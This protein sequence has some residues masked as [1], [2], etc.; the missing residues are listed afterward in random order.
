MFGVTNLMVH[1]S[2]A[3]GNGSSLGMRDRLAVHELMTRMEFLQRS[4]DSRRDIDNECGYPA[5]VSAE[6]Y[7]KLWKRSGIARRVVNIFPKESWKKWPSIIED[8]DPTT[9]TTFEQ[10]ILDLVKEKML[11][12]YLKRADIMSGIG[13]YGVLLL[14]VDD[15]AAAQ[16]DLS[17]PIEGVTEDEQPAGVVSR[18]LLWMRVFAENKATIAKYNTNK[19]SPRFMHPEQYSLQ[20]TDG[21]QTQSMTV[22]WTRCLHFADNRGES[23]IAGSPRMESEYNRLYDLNKILGAS[24]EGYWKGAF[25]GIASELMAGFEDAEVDTDAIRQAIWNYQNTLQRHLITPGMTNKTLDP[26]ILGPYEFFETEIK[27]ICVGIDVPLRVFLGT[28]EGKLAGE[29]DDSRWDDRVEGR[30]V[31]YLNPCVVEP[32]I[33]RLQAIGVCSAPEDWRADWPDLKD[34][35]DREESEV[36]LIKTQAISEY[37]RG[38]CNEF[39]PEEEYL[40]MFLNMDQEEVE[41]IIEA[42]E[43]RVE[44]LRKEEE[45]Q[46]RK[47][48]DAGLLDEEDDDDNDQVPPPNQG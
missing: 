34:T 11:W 48:I 10:E 35:S 8:D 40:S 6:Q 3:S 32:T 2:I 9:T 37:V 23:D 39:I 21:V 38:G 12:H 1:N 17:Q 4:L 47:A 42:M 33:K 13:K 31:D 5:E 16:G 36:A 20:M 15:Q 29:Q 46:M 24:G 41:Q 7:Y 30:R 28:E 18:K 43:K 45:D 14:G 22:H 25:Q 27:A 26:S 19:A 44:E